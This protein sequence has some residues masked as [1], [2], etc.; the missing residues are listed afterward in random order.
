M[1]DH[2]LRM[3]AYVQLAWLSHQKRQRLRRDQFFLLAGVEACRAGWPQLGERCRELLLTS[4]P[5]H[6]ASKFSSLADALRNAD[7]QK[8]VAQHERH[9]PSERAEHV[10]ADLGID[11]RGDQPERSRGDRMRELLDEIII[12]ASSSR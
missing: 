4:N 7:F 6:M 10:L 11:P 2:E 8:L 3:C 12:S 5:H 1:I 9:Y